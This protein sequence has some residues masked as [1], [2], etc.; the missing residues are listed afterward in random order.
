MQAVVEVAIENTGLQARTNVVVGEV[1][2]TSNVV[3]LYGKAINN[4]IVDTGASHHIC[5]DSSLMD[6][7]F[8]IRPIEAGLPNGE[9]TQAIKIGCVKF[10][11]KLTLKNVLFVLELNCNFLSVSQLLFQDQLSLHFTYTKCV[12]QD[13]TL[14]MKI[15]VGEQIRGLYYLTMGE[16]V[17]VSVVSVLEAALW[18]K[19]LGHP[20][21][22]C[23]ACHCFAFV[24]F[25]C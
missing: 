21:L 6:S 23:K 3:R 18:H 10:N 17:W 8:N 19:R 7:L 12:V 9:T 24:W 25:S 15:G 16:P 2:A 1:P 5:Y 22:V 11:D 13:H 20:P 14:R 4:W